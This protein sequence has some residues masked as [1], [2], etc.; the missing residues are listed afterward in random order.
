MKRTI[1]Y[2]F[3]ATA[4]ATVGAPHLAPELAAAVAAYMIDE[5]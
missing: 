5:E 2:L 3:V 1:I 4:L